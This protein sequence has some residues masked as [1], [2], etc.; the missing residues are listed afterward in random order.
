MFIMIF[1]SPIYNKKNNI[2]PLPFLFCDLK[3]LDHSI[4]FHFTILVSS[5]PNFLFLLFSFVYSVRLP[6]TT[7]NE[8]VVLLYAWF[9]A[10]IVPLQD[11]PQGFCTS[12]TA[13][14]RWSQRYAWFSAKN[15]G[16]P[17]SKHLLLGS[18]W[19]GPRRKCEISSPCQ[20]RST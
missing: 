9:S 20:E 13:R 8:T 14:S 19:A 10:K 3:K 2:R 7:Y 1:Y 18:I 12:G 5:K 17:I 16:G 6:H 15:N 11:C 4:D